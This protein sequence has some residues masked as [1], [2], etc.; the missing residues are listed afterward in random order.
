LKACYKTIHDEANQDRNHVINWAIHVKNELFDIGL[1]H[2]WCNQGYTCLYYDIYFPIVKQRI[3]D[4][5]VQNIVE[6]IQSSSRC[7]I[8]MYIYDYFSMQFY[9]M[10]A[11]PHVYK[12]QISRIRM[13][14]HNLAIESGRHQNVARMHRNCKLCNLEIGDEFPFYFKVNCV[15][16]Y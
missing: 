11:I 13:S 7:R 4:I 14:S 9:L 16:N 10:K 15:A 3:T 2:I 12:K 8:Y 1:C 5:Y 6:Q